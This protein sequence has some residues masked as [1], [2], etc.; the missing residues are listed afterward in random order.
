MSQVSIT[1]QADAKAWQA[2]CEEL[3]RRAEEAVKAM[4]DLLETIGQKVKGNLS[5][6]LVSIGNV[7]MER[8]TQL[9]QAMQVIF[10]L[11]NDLLGLVGDFIQKGMEFL[12]NIGRG[13]NR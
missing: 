11:V 3:N 10:D 6:E 4:G 13:V 7:V 12:G 2:S 5:D 8:A 1:S 9:M